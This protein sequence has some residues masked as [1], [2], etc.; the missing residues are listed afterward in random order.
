VLKLHFESLIRK[1]DSFCARVVRLFTGETACARGTIL[2][3][4]WLSPEQRLQF[5]TTRS[6]L[7]VGCDTGKRYCIRYGTAT[8]VFEVDEAGYTVTG[9][10][11]LPA[12]ELVAG[13]VMLAQKIALEN[14]EIAALRVARRFPVN[15]P[16]KWQNL[17]QPY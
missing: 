6:F 4:E 15:I 5:E 12:G 11:F 3:N 10:C 1:A 16:R 7:V 8:N 9:W 17:L 13:D 14:D 2:L